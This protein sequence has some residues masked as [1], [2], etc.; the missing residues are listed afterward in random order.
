MIARFISNPKSAP[1]RIPTI[2]TSEQIQSRGANTVKSFFVV[3]AYIV[4]ATTTA[5]VNKEA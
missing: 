1:Q 5:D 4:I 3:I 2:K